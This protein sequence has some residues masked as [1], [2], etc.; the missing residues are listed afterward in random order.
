L[1][2]Y[3]FVVS[4]TQE[5][6][7]SLPW[8]KSY[9]LQK[10]G[11]Y[12]LGDDTPGQYGSRTSFGGYFIS[13]GLISYWDA[14]KT[15]NEIANKIVDEDDALD[16]GIGHSQ[17]D[18]SALEGIYR[19]AKKCYEDGCCRKKK[20]IKLT[21]LA[22]KTSASYIDKIHIGVGQYQP[23]WFFEILIVYSSSDTFIPKRSLLPW[24]GSYK[25]TSYA[26]G[27]YYLEPV[28]APWYKFISS[29]YT[30]YM[31][32]EKEFYENRGRELESKIRGFFQ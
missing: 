1:G 9:Y 31:T 29:H 4:G 11:K 28:E 14:A 19:A 26:E 8:E 30:D 21:L 32:G 27:H 20:N 13:L 12:L 2:Q 18:A 7:I 17:G 24:F 5:Y 22:P 15:G 10:R 23:E 3:D 16:R 6:L 25:P